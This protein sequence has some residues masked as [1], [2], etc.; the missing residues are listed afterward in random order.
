L[1]FTGLLALVPSRSALTF[2]A[3][4]LNVADDVPNYHEKIGKFVY[5]QLHVQDMGYDKGI[6]RVFDGAF[7]YVNRKFKLVD[8]S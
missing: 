2:L 4:I 8:C 6:S 1:L 5:L 7:E 3:H